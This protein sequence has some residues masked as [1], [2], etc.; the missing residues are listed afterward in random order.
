MPK[1]LSKPKKANNSKSN[2]AVGTSHEIP[3]VVINPRRHYRLAFLD[4]AIETPPR[5]FSGSITYQQMMAALVKQLAEHKNPELT[6]PPATQWLVW[7]NLRF[8]KAQAWGVPFLG[9]SQ[10]QGVKFSLVLVKDAQAQPSSE[11][12]DYAAGASDRPYAKVEGGELNWS[13]ASEGA[14][15]VITMTDVDVLYVDVEVW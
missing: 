12:F 2:A 7:R 3:P 6:I 14:R 8:V 10:T 5:P 13:T 1:V 11:I 4:T 9:T 15:S